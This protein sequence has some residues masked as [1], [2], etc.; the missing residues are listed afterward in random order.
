[1]N[2]K[3]EDAEIESR[4][5]V[6]LILSQAVEFG[7]F[8]ESRYGNKR[9]VRYD[10]RINDTPCTASLYVEGDRRELRLSDADV[11]A[12][13]AYIRKFLRDA[14]TDG[15]E[16]VLREAVHLTHA[17]GELTEREFLKAVANYMKDA[18]GQRLGTDITKR[19]RRD[20]QK[21]QA[22]ATVHRDMAF[23]KQYR[24]DYR[25]LRREHFRGR[26]RADDKEFVKKVWRKHE[27]TAFAGHSPEYLELALRVAQAGRGDLTPKQAALE[28]ASQ[29]LRISPQTVERHYVYRRKKEAKTS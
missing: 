5:Q 17:K 7:C 29:Q 11:E 12:A 22:T 25:R 20:W 18:S 21:F 2:V 19:K 27:R 24:A 6:G 9:R 13:C 16:I 26:H 23:F 10:V 8:V 28:W 15:I 1:M 14:I 3:S 4:R